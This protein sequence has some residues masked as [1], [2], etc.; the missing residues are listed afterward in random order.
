MTTATLP[1]KSMEPWLKDDIEYY[2]HQVIGVRHLINQNSFLLCDEMGLGK[3]LEAIT[4]F[5]ADVMRGMSKTCLVVCPLT[6]KE[7]WSD[8]WE[9]FTRIPSVRLEGKSKL[10]RSEIITDFARRDEPRVM[11]VNYE[12]VVAHLDEFNKLRFDVIIFD[13][14]HYMKNYRSQR[15]K[16]CLKLRSGRSFMLTGTP[17]LNNV[18]ELWPLLHKVDSR[19]WGAYWG[20]VNRYCVFGGFQN[21]AIIGTKNEEEL[22]TE[23]SRVMLRRL[24]RD[25]LPLK[26]PV[27]ITKKVT[28]SEG[29]RKLYDR[30]ANELL[31]TGADGEDSD[32]DNAL[33][34]F[35]RLKQICGTTAPFNG[36]DDSAKMDMAL[37]DAIELSQND[38]K[39][40]VFTQFI[41]VMD[42][43]TARLSVVGIPTWQI[44]GRVKAE[45]RQRIVKEWSMDPRPG[46]IVCMLQVAGIGLNMTAARHIQFLDKLYVPGLNQQAIF[47][48]NRIGADI[49]QAVTVFDYICRDTIESRIEEILRGKIKT[50][51]DVV[52]GSSAWKKSFLNEL[53]EA[54]V[55]DARG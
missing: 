46:A 14:A 45:D 3:S 42:A 47:R 21:K 9:K 52:E 15:T 17:V 4:V 41:E 43:Y 53:K 23:L 10:K 26:D 55:R 19:R 11:I 28:L 22:R 48:A 50:V 18:S 8:E 1:R 12:Q 24:S 16:A 51:Q 5:C 25:V 54:V 40:I 32:I 44:S 7:N 35:L 6:V 27:P 38:H 31:L 49:T 33:T 20:F 37:E 2:D 13:E 34:K 36:E 30:V 29:Q 39:I